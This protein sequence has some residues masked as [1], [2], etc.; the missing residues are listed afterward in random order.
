MTRIVVL[1]DC[2]LDNGQLARLRQL[3]DVEVHHGVPRDPEEIE[4]R[5]KGADVAV[6]GWTALEGDVLARLPDL[7]MVSVWATGYDYV[8]TEAADRLGITVTNVPAYAG[9]AVAELTLG[10][11]LALCRNIPLGNSRVRGGDLSWQGLRGIELAERTLGLVG[12][13]DIG[14]KVA[15]IGRALGMRV[16]AHAREMSDERAAVL[17]VEFLPLTELL[18]AS[19]FVSLHTPLTP[20][21]AGLIGAGEIAAMK[22]GAFLINTARAGLVDQDALFRALTEGRLAGAALDDLDPTRS[23]IILLDNVVATPHI[24]FFTDSALRQKGDICVSNVEEFLRSRPQNVVA[25]PE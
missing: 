3:G 17:G 18:A 11:M 22:P 21:T 4:R 10:L 2:D 20:K 6:L 8:D 13:G 16:L 12:V 25:G 15:R 5:L 1:D 14:E 24:G 23:D 9:S 19:D 7:R